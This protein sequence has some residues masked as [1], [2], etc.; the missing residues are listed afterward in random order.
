MVRSDHERCARNADAA[1]M[2]RRFLLTTCLLGVLIASLLPATARTAGHSRTAL[3]ALDAAVVAELNEIRAAHG[4]APLALNR[5]LATAARQHSTDM[6]VKGYFAHESSDGSPFWKRVKQYYGA[7]A[8]GYWLVGEN[9]VWSAPDLEAKEAVA[10]WMGSPPHRK[11]ILAAGWREVG[12]GSIHTDAASGFATGPLTIVTAD[13]GV[14][15]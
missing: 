3:A 15:R 8:G 13:F 10:L 9:I 14:R 11:I 4:L 7:P 5:Q 12:I 2:A 1:A 6:V